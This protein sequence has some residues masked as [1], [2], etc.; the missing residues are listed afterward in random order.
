MTKGRKNTVDRHRM[1]FVENKSQ[2]MRAAR[3]AKADTKASAIAAAAE[4][5]AE[6]A[7]CR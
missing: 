7:D 4:S 5:E 1:H 3:L 6:E 2:Q